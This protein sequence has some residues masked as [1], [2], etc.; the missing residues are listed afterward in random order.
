MV[1]MVNRPES[2]ESGRPIVSIP[3]NVHGKRPTQ[4]RAEPQKERRQTAA[5]ALIP[6]FHNRFRLRYRR[7]RGELNSD[8]D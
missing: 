2:R 7:A 1:D 3:E 4:P 5:P 6:I 8:T